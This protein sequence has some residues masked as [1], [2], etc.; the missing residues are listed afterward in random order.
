M[1]IFQIFIPEP[2]SLSQILRISPFIKEKWGEAIR[3]EVIV[4]FDN[5]TFLLNENPL[6]VDEIIPAKL[7]CKTKLSIY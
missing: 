3:P 1:L 7:A 5:D 2:N 6:P 4:L